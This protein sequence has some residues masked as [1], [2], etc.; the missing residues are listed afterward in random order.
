MQCKNDHATGSGGRSAQPNA[1]GSCSIC[2][3]VDVMMWACQDLSQSQV[4]SHAKQQAPAFSISSSAPAK[5][6]DADALRKCEKSEDAAAEFLRDFHE[7]LS[8]G[9]LL[10]VL[11]ATTTAYINVAPSLPLSL[12]LSQ[13]SCRKRFSGVSLFAASFRRFSKASHVDVCDFWG[14]TSRPARQTLEWPPQSRS[15][16]HSA[17]KVK[18]CLLRLRGVLLARGHMAVDQ[19]LGLRRDSSACFPRVGA[20]SNKSP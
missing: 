13:L 8:G 10:L 9:R 15:L 6:K 5:H 2:E 12:S 1:R 19:F 14:L 17:A 18:P 11:L 3:S 16:K 4:T 20:A 7:C